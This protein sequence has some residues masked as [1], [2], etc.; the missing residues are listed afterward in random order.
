MTDPNQLSPVDD[1]TNQLADAVLNDPALDVQEGYAPVVN[2]EPAPVAAVQ[3]T[4]QQ[5]VQEAAPA[6]APAPAPTPSP[7]A[8]DF[9]KIEQLRKHMMLTGDNMAD[10]IGVSRIT[11]YNWVKGGAVRKTNAGKLRATLIKL[12][13]LMKSGWPD[14]DVIIMKGPDRFARLLELMKDPV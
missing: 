5:T 13:T 3:E 7:S 14:H 11:Y 8:F 1:E 4:V 12:M 10:L 9:S 6:P 2:P